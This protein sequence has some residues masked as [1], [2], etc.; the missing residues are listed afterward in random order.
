MGDFLLLPW[1]TMLGR[2]LLAAAAGAIVGIERE[3]R[4]HA[5]GFRT[6]LLVSA[7]SCLFT[8]TSIVGAGTTHDPTRIAAGIVTG[9][10]FLGAGA[11]MRQGGGIQ[12]LTT[13]ASIW[14]VSAVG[15][16]A[17]FGWWQAVIV[18]TV[19]MFVALTLLKW[20]E[21][22]LLRPVHPAV[23]RVEVEAAK[24]PLTALRE[25]CAADD[26][27][28]VSLTVNRAEGG[29]EAWV[30]TIDVE[31]LPPPRADELVGTLSRIDGVRSVRLG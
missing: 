11:I 18:G 26:R 3:R 20:V 10:G 19:L 13:A 14:A 29:P 25:A 8:L 17:G 27:Q 24:L 28:A 16:A 21:R 22:K 15:M 6:M 30:V 5:A 12:G 23:I 4:D 2:L 31:H 9:I 1:Q 7:G